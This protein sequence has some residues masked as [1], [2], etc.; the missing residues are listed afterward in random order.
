MENLTR[1]ARKITFILFLEQS[2]ASAG[3]IAAATLNSIVGAK[4]SLHSDWAGVPTAV[5]LLAGAFSAFMWGYVMEAIGRRGGLTL[6]LALGVLGSGFAFY[7][8]AKS[9]FTWFLFGMIFMGVANR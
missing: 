7:A 9:S 8:I 6:G 5:Y 1:I 3:F 4:L 2:L